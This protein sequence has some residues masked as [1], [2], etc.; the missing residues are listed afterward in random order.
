MYL[1][2]WATLCKQMSLLTRAGQSVGFVKV[3]VGLYN[4]RQQ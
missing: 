2:C 3:G 4:R 1:T